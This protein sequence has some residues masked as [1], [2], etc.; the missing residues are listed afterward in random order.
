MSMITKSVHE[1]QTQCHEK[2]ESP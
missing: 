1:C 2:H